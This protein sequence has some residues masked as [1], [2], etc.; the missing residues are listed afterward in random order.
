MNSKPVQQKATN[1]RA[2][3]GPIWVKTFLS[4]LRKTGNVTTAC[5]KAKIERSTAYRRKT[6]DKD[7]SAAWTVALDE[8]ADHLE[9]EAWRRAVAG[10]LKP[11][12]QGGKRVGQVREYSDT[13]LALL[14]K[15]HKPEKYRER[16]D[17]KVELDVTQ[18]SD[19]ELRQIV[20]D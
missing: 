20:E 13:M 14:L 9:A 18:L 4:V 1:D 17:H 19:D 15:A 3:M 7:F 2:G 5:A 11:V 8:A 6:D 12:F 16:F 10:V